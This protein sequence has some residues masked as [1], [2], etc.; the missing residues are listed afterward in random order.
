MKLFKFFKKLN[1]INLNSFLFKQFLCF[2]ECSEIKRSVG[3]IP[4]IP[5]S[6]RDSFSL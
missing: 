2:F 5:Q 4:R 1:D 6:L 3:R